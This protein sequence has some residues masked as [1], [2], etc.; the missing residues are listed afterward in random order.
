[1]SKVCLM[2]G[3]DRKATKKAL[4]VTELDSFWDCTILLTASN[5]CKH[6][7]H[8]HLHPVIHSLAEMTCH[9][10]R[11]SFE[12]ATVERAIFELSQL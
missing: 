11:R 6:S 4:F 5:A 1:M 7:P 2:G 3:Q 8:C 10:W 9:S 12:F